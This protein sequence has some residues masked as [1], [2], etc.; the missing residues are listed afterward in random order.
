MWGSHPKTSSSWV[1]A[2]PGQWMAQRAM[3]SGASRP[4]HP[5]RV[6][7][8]TVGLSTNPSAIRRP[9]GS[10]PAA[11]GAPLCFFWQLLLFAVPCSGGGDGTGVRAPLSRVPLALRGISVPFLPHLR[12]LSPRFCGRE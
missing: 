11:L 6:V 12:V 4:L 7:W 8:D 5:K 9:S 1:P 2:E 3:H 10:I